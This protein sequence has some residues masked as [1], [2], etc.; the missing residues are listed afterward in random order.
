MSQ[1]TFPSS[2]RV[3]IG[4][5]VG[6]PHAVL[7]VLVKRSVQAVPCFSPLGAEV[8]V[9]HLVMLCSQ[10]PMSSCR[11]YTWDFVEAFGTA[12]VMFVENGQ[13]WS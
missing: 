1:Q 4:H 5:L 11:G 2:E 3:L 8:S 10:S 12:T 13:Q 9:G 7:R 6:V